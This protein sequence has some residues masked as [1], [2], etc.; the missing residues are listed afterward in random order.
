VVT[1]CYQYIDIRKTGER[2]L[3]VAC[4]ITLGGR[5][6]GRQPVAAAHA[7]S[8]NP[9]ALFDRWHA[10]GDARFVVY[11]GEMDCFEKTRAGTV[12]MR[13]RCV[14]QPPAVIG[15][16]HKRCAM[17]DGPTGWVLWEE[18]LDDEIRVHATGG[19][20]Q[21]RWPA[22]QGGARRR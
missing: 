3:R 17:E 10:H 18:G 13:S 14:M 5:V 9:C 15:W 7:G 16:D 11:C 12:R 19:E 20:E 8:P 6:A 1:F 2:S 4:R 21:L 22:R